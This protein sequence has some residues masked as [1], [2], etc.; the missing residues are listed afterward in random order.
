[1]KH[2]KNIILTTLALVFALPIAASAQRILVP[3]D[4]AQ[5]NHLKAYGVVFW[6]LESG[7]QAQWLLNYRGGS[8]LM[9]KYEGLEDRLLTRG[10]TYSEITSGETAAILRTI[11]V[12]NMEKVQ[13]EKPPSIAV[14]SPPSHQPWDDAVTLALNYAEIEYESIWDRSEEHTSE[15]Q[16]H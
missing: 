7:G 12:E 10:V 4:V 11:E 9:D 16:S 3:M 5:A 1:M 13:L 8:F 2:Y 15:L 6:I 14:Y